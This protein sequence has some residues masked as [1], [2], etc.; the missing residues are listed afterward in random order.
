MYDAATALWPRQRLLTDPMAYPLALKLD[1]GLVIDGL[2]ITLG[3][4]VD[5]D[6][7]TTE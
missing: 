7:P 1:N 5:W 2:D 3:R 6:L 4:A